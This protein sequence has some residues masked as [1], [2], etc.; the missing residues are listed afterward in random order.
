MTTNIA[1][2]PSG[3]LVL[4]HVWVAFLLFGV[5]LLLGVY[6][7]LARDGVLGSHA[8][9]YYA[10]T[11]LHGVVM[12]YALTIFFITGIGYAISE[13]ALGTRV[14]APGLAWLCFWVMLA[15]TV[16]AALSIL[17]GKASVLYTFYP[18]QMA[19][20]SFYVGAALLV[21]GSIGWIVITLVM[22]AQWKGAH[23][24]Q[25][26]PLAQFGMSI[27]ALVWAW[28][29]VGVVLEVLLQLIP[30]A[31]GLTQSIDV[32][33]ARALFAWTLHPIVYFWLIPTYVF[34]YTIVPEEA[35]GYL[36]SDEMARVAFV[37]LL[38]FGLPI[39]MHHLYMDP[40]HSAG[41]K[42]LQGIGTFLVVIPTMLTGFTV[43]ASLEIS[44]RLRGGT[45]LFGWM[46]RL[47]WDDPVVLA[48][49][50]ALFML[51]LGGFG[52]LVNAAY[53]QNAMVHNTQWVTA[54]FHY[55]FGGV[56]VTGYFGLAYYFWPRLTGR[57]LWAPKLALAQI[58]LWIIGMN[59][60]SLP[61]HYVGLLGM[62]RRIA[63][64]AY[65][66]EIAAQWLPWTGIMIIGGV[67]L[68]LSGWLLLLILFL[69][70]RTL[71]ASSATMA[72]GFA[73]PYEATAV[74]PRSLNGFALWNWLLLALMA[75][76][77]GYPIVQ[78]FLV[79]QYP[80]L[81]WGFS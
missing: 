25:N 75:M 13:R 15:G 81:P 19:H 59:I 36:F 54:H 79:K 43:W 46:R 23:R 62:P 4:A 12:G 33:L 72:G 47:K 35:G 58:W 6:Q 32:N 57:A 56:A 76:A 29:M 21:A 77:W 8:A 70:G 71:P 28:T 61:W 10:S 20:W 53:A 80:A 34:L 37:M 51:I 44:G 52:G 30:L 14:W 39:G 27:C 7:V 1:P 11:T 63:Y 67:L 64:Y 38:I 22:S 2:A 73:R 50:M 60:L 45:G 66:P 42:L 17:A 74:L 78:F 48:G 26:L 49:V 24:G 31:F 65:A 3:R 5:A 18:P 69:S 41:F 55:I 16:L 9:S 40:P 68:C